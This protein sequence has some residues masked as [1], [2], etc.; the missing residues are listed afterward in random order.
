MRNTDK[1]IYRKLDFGRCTKI[2]LDQH[3]LNIILDTK[4][5]FSYIILYIIQYLPCCNKKLILLKRSH[6]S[7]KTNC[8]I[9]NI[10]IINVLIIVV[11]IIL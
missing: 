11:R 3:A 8:V 6:L 9:N 7:Y 5:I 10:C 2:K 1:S 4:I